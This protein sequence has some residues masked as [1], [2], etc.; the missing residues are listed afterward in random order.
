M[1]RWKKAAGLLL[2]GGLLLQ[3]PAVSG[4][5]AAGNDEGIDG[6]VY[7]I[8]SRKELAEADTASYVSGQ[9]RYIR[10]PIPENSWP[11]PGNI[12]RLLM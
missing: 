7:H 8:D 11:A 12:D 9:G 4:T 5:V 6:S 3:M 1:A 2:C 10:M